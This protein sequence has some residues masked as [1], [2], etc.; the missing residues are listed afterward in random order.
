MERKANRVRED[1]GN[2]IDEE[3]ARLFMA[4]ESGDMSETER[5]RLLER[6]NSILSVPLNVIVLEV[7]GE[8]EYRRRDG[9]EGRMFVLKVSLEGEEGRIIFWDSQIELLDR[10]GISPGDV[11]ELNNCNSSRGRYGL[12]VVPGKFGIIRVREGPVIYRSLK[13]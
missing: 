11:L 12:T 10:S 2:L 6:L 13:L 9:G 8:R 3:T 7:E 5:T 1:F 4:Y